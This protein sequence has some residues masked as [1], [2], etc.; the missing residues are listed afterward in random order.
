MSTP[1]YQEY[2]D[3]QRLE[4]RDMFASIAREGCHT[5]EDVNKVG[6]KVAEGFSYISGK[7]D[8][9]VGEV[10]YK[11]GE[12]ACG[13]K[14]YV[15]NAKTEIKDNTDRYYISGEANADVRAKNLLD[16]I[17][18]SQNSSTSLFESLQSNVSNSRER[19]QE[20]LY[21]QNTV[22]VAAHRDTILELTKDIC[23]VQKDIAIG[24]GQ[25]SLEHCRDTGALSKQMSEGFAAVQLEAAK[26]KFD[27]SKQLSDCCCEMKEKLIET[28][29]ATQQLI[30][31]QEN[32]RLRDSLAAAANENLY[33]RLS[34]QNGGGHGG[35]P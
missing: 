29:S 16:S 15:G 20:Q 21:E 7:I 27:L 24:F 17:L 34:G 11:V 14:E 13:V 12:S 32:N 30:R 35:R 8:S 23:G 3:H 6:G 1:A 5:R 25:G 33:L 4:H 26:N 2:P 31:D 22:N 19:L 28:A 9:G 18:N 10:K